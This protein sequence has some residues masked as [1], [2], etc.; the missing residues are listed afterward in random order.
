[1]VTYVRVHEWWSPHIQSSTFTEVLIQEFVIEHLLS[2]CWSS[3]PE[4]A[5]QFVLLSYVLD[6]LK[7]TFYPLQLRN[8]VNIELVLYISARHVL[9][10]RRLLCLGREV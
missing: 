10:R 3:S 6:V 1:M 9:Y 2:V 5:V 7:A 4:H 8:N